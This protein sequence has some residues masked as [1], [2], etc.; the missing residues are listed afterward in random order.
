MSVKKTTNSDGECTINGVSEGKHTLTAHKDG[1]NEFRDEIDVNG[2]HTTVSVTLIKKEIKNVFD[3]HFTV[4]DEQD[5]PIQNATVELEG[6]SRTTGSA[7]GCNFQNI[8]EGEHTLNISADGYKPITN[9]II[10][11]DEGNT[12]FKFILKTA[13]KLQDVTVELKYKE[14]AE[15]VEGAEVNLNGENQI[16]D[17]NGKCTFKNVPYASHPVRVF[18]EGYK[19]V[20]DTIT[21]PRDNTP[22]TT[23]IVAGDSITLTADK[24]AIGEGESAIFTGHLNSST[25]PSSPKSMKFLVNGAIKWSDLVDSSTQNAT[26]KYTSESAGRIAVTA[27]YERDIISNVLY[28]D[29]NVAKGRDVNLKFIDHD[30]KQPVAGAWFAIH[31][32]NWGYQVPGNADE[33]GLATA[34]GVL[35]GTYIVSATASGYDTWEKEGIT[36]DSG[37]P[38]IIVDFV[39]KGSE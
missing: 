38:L 10:G 13:I 20:T 22:W 27:E 12:E 35:D 11:V 23:K 26:F 16:T 19:T 8:S 2:S 28:L 32:Q 6:D 4:V 1:Y 37:T 36:V 25:I 14:S 39:P 7:G 15:R 33:Q 18:K 30:T 24:T 3:V 5:Q 17:K 9:Q 29:D 31:N 34:K 21:V